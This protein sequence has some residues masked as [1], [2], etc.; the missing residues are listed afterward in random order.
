MAHAHCMLDIYK[1]TNTLTEYVTRRF[2]TA[3]LITIRLTFVHILR[4]A[5][6][7]ISTYKLPDMPTQ[8]YFS[9]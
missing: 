3:I 6:T 7:V 9:C 1:A 5:V 4:V 8:A 2:S